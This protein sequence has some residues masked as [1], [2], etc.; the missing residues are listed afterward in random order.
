MFFHAADVFLMSVTVGIRSV[1]TDLARVARRSPVSRSPAEVAVWFANPAVGSP[2]GGVFM[3]TSGGCPELAS[4]GFQQGQ[5]HFC[6]TVIGKS[7]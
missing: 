6:C 2:R 7:E 4:L 3:S 5:A 1:A